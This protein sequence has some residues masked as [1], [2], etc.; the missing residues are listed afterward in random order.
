VTSV[1]LTLSVPSQTI[2]FEVEPD[3]YGAFPISATYYSGTTL[4][5][6]IFQ[7]ING[8]YGALL[9]G[10]SSTLPIT[11]VVAT[12][13]A[14]AGG[15]AMA[16]LRYGS[17]LEGLGAP[18]PNLPTAAMVAAG[19]LL[20]RAQKRPGQKVRIIIIMEIKIAQAMGQCYRTR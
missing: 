4:L 11:S 17:T 18:I 5:G 16:Q 13:P 6:T 1:T 8:S 10:G 20:A 7:S 15:L 12:V 2:G 9:A 14:A 3:N 19:A